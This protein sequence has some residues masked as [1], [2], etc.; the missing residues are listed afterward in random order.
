MRNHVQGDVLYIDSDTIILSDLSDIDSNINDI[1][2]VNELNRPFTESTSKKTLTEIYA[3]LGENINKIEYYYNSGVIYIKDNE[4]TKTFFSEW[5]EL[6]EEGTKKGI[7]FD[8]PSLGLI[9]YKK[10]NVISQMDGIWNCQGRYSVNYAKG[11]KIF[12]YLYD[13]GFEFPLLNKEV[14]SELKD[15]GIVSDRIKNIL[16]NP[17][18]SISTNNIIITDDDV[19]LFGSKLYS[20]IRSIYRHKWIYKSLEGTLNKTYSIFLYL[21][22]RKLAPPR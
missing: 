15:K 4:R 3:R 1:A 21:K 19:I 14:F 16:K 18:G 6:W 20:L 5:K 11:A 22:S 8:Q 10:G 9:N 13:Q 2:A 17:Y 7:F 12:H